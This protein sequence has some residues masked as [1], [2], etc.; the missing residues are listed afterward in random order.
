VE[1]LQTLAAQLPA[2][3]RAPICIVQHIGRHPSELPRLL[4]AAGPLPAAHAEDGEPLREARI[5]VAPPDR[6]LVI[7]EGHLRLVRGPRENFAR[8]AID[9]LFRSAAE[10]F[11]A[12]AIGVIL[13]GR[14]NDGTAGLYEIKRRGGTAI[15]QAPEEAQYRDMPASALEHVKVD[16]CLRLAEMPPV[17]ERLAHEAAQPTLAQQPLEEAT[18]MSTAYRLKRPATLTCPDCGGA[19]ERT[20]LGTLTQYRCHIGHSYTAEAMAA[21]QFTQMEGGIE[22]ALRMLNERIEICRQMAERPD[23]PDQDQRTAWLAAKEQAEQRTDTI[24][25]LL[26]A[27]WLSPED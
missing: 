21:A 6:H 10:T 26:S 22:A 13:S 27:G 17:L 12:G 16:H 4:T 25:E 3:L 15:V 20:E 18:E 11:G 2:T 9:P 7:E 23:A 24:S 14:L 1:A 19:L 8:P 5:Y